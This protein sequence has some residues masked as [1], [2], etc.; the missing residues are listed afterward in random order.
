MLRYLKRGFR[1]GRI[2]DGLFPKICRGNW[3]IMVILRGAAHPIMKEE[4]RLP[5]QWKNTQL[6]IA[7]P[8]S[9]HT[10]KRDPSRPCK[11]IVAHFACLHPVMDNFISRTQP[12]PFSL[13]AADLKQVEELYQRLLR[14]YK[15][16]SLSSPLIFEHG[17]LEFCL[18]IL[19]NLKQPVLVPG[20]DVNSTKVQQ[21]ISWYQEHLSEGID[22]RDVAS[23]VGLS[24]SHLRRLFQSVLQDTPKRVFQRAGLENA[25]RLMSETGLSLKEIAY[26]SGYKGFSQFHRAFRAQY[27]QAPEEWRRNSNY[28]GL[29]VRSRAGHS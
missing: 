28:R 10:W 24:S 19:K 27:N 26:L 14:E 3:E 11:V 7:P 6:W 1:D 20:F 21:A 25:C 2:W 9:M 23:A 22:V 5:L 8:Y 16:P 13:T 17:M 29:G 18:L 15:S 4:T 12:T